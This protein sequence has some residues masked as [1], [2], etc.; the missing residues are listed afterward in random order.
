VVDFF[1]ELV[2]RR[3]LADNFCSYNPHYDTPA[4]YPEWAKKTH[5][6]HVSDKRDYTYTR[7][8]LEQGWTHDPLWN[9]AQREMVKTGKMHGYMRM[10][11]CKKILEW[12]P[13]VEVA[14]ET[15]IFL[16]DRYELDGRDP[17]GY[18]G[19]AWSL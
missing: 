15:A 8:E 19:I 13:S 6:K 2:V 16:N 4:G 7:E 5:Q 12:T 14:H 18:T 3:E 1:E 11:W 17:S 10:Y 9:A